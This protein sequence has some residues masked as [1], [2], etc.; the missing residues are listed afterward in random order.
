MGFL[1]DLSC[2]KILSLN[3]STLLFLHRTSPPYNIETSADP[4]T[5]SLATS[6]QRKQYR[7]CLNWTYIGLGNST[8][9]LHSLPLFHLPPILKMKSSLVFSALILSSFK[10]VAAD[11]QRLC[12]E[13]CWTHHV[14]DRTC[15]DNCFNSLVRTYALT[16]SDLIVCPDTRY[17]LL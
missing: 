11:K 9:L 4:S 8:T 16:F 7:Y 15:P 2:Y 13:V 14:L 17:P 10:L 6:P 5:I 3:L 1:P 12:T